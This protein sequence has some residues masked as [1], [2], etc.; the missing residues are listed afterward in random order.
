MTY[1]IPIYE[2]DSECYAAAGL[3]AGQADAQ[4]AAL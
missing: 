4:N 3:K 1:N 2:H